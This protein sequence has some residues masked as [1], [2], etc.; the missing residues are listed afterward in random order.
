MKKRINSIFKLIVFT[1]FILG[2]VACSND[3]DYSTPKIIE[4]Q[5]P[6]TISENENEIDNNDDDIVS[7]YEDSV[8]DNQCEE[9]EIITDTNEE[10]TDAFETYEPGDIFT[11]LPEKFTFAS[12]I[13]AWATY[14]YISKDGS[15]V[16]DYHDSDMGSIGADY[17]YG[18]VYKCDFSG[19]FSEPEP[20]DN[21][22]IYSMKLQELIIQDEE[23]LDTEEIVD[24]IRYIYTTPYGFDDADEFILYM[25]G[26]PLEEIPDEG[27]SWTGLN[28]SV[29]DKVPEGFFVIYNVCGQKSF[30][31][32]SEDSI[33]NG[34]YRFEYEDAYAIFSPIY[35]GSYLLFFPDSDS[36][37]S[38]S[39]KVPWDGKN[40]NSMV[41]E[42]YWVNDK[43]IKINVTVKIYRESNS[44]VSYEI[45]L[46]HLSEPQFD[47]SEWGSDEPG[48]FSGVFTE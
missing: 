47:F 28:S 35:Y 42:N 29:S 39:V 31:A 34:D 15:F 23:K 16:G 6:E 2:C 32:L 24:G 19:K 36:P 27:L 9:Q 45:T 26:T 37:A 8:S 10:L 5:I 14:I 21:P 38:F 48:K 12:G 43:K 41:C 46:E 4:I 30:C 11:V 17:P 20:T 22:Y 7:E 44:K 18:T 13:G 3:D 25:P 33:W 1:V 40:E